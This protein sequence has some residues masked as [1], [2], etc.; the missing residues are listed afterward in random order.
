M[1]LKSEITHTLEMIVMEKDTALVYR[2]GELPVLA[3]PAMAALM[4]ETCW[5][6]VAPY[7]EEGQGT[8]GTRLDLVHTAATPVGM[9][10]TCRSE[11]TEVDGRR[12]VFSVEVTLLARR[13]PQCRGFKSPSRYFQSSCEQQELFSF[14]LLYCRSSCAMIVTKNT[15]SLLPK[16]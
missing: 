6:S 16:N 4:E 2:S 9:N 13:Y 1:N 15:G 8:V 7:L 14:L 5:K 3:T 11:L 10:V 12:L